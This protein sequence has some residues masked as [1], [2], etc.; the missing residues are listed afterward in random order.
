MRRG[1]LLLVAFAA[2]Y[3]GSFAAGAIQADLEGLR[4][5]WV[6]VSIRTGPGN[7]PQRERNV[8]FTFSKDRKVVLKQGDSGTEGTFMI[9]SDKTPK[10]IDIT[11]TKP[12]GAKE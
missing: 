3:G 11:T 1:L 2:L 9:N 4:G 5:T 7:Q 12:G 6:L 8:S 10:E